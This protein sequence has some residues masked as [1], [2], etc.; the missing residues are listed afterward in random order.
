MHTDKRPEGHII[1]LFGC[2]VLFERHAAMIAPLASSR[3]AVF[4]IH[5]KLTR[6]RLIE[7]ICK[8]SLAKSLRGAQYEAAKRR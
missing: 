8:I 1:V 7:E 2:H 5:S 3:Q 4:S 6:I